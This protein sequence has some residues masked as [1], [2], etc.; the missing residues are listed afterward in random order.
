MNW[1]PLAVGN[2]DPY[3]EPRAGSTGISWA[4]HDNTLP[5]YHGL[6]VVQTGDWL[7]VLDDQ[8]RPLWEGC[9][10]LDFENGWQPYADDPMFG[11]QKVDDRPVN[12][13]QRTVD[14]KQWLAWFTARHRAVLFR[15]AEAVG[16]QSVSPLIQAV[17]ELPADRWV[18]RAPTRFFDGIERLS[19]LERNR[20]VGDLQ[21][22][23]AWIAHALGWTH[24]QVAASLD[25]PE[26]LAAQWAAPSDLPW[27]RPVPPN[28]EWETRSAHLLALYA[29]LH[30]T[31]GERI[32]DQASW[33]SGARALLAQACG[34][35]S[36][37][38]GAVA[39][40]A[41]DPDLLTPPTF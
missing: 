32:G 10:D 8:L 33:S 16:G 11:Q 5:G 38:Q 2:L 31:L 12:G 40:L 9:I 24:G 15:P 21:P 41:P 18:W 1:F 28:P 23:V 7:R 20:I 14:P 29:H 27:H 30:W 25:I 4:V 34:S 22:A 35:L 17:A 36:A 6:L 37:L 3:V 19:A 26:S 13:V 39:E